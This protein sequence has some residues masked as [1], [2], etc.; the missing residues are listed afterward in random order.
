MTRCTRDILS[1]LAENRTG[2]GQP[3]TDRRTAGWNLSFSS[4]GFHPWPFSRSAPNATPCG[5]G[6]FTR[7][8][9]A[10]A[11]APPAGISC[12]RLAGHTPAGEAGKCR[13]TRS[14]R[15][16]SAANCTTCEPADPVC[17]RERPGGQRNRL[18]TSGFRLQVQKKKKH[19]AHA[20]LLP[21][22]KPV[23]CSLEPSARRAKP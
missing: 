17:G 6:S 7:S 19:P 16:T 1:D 3:G 4:E 5:R 18:Q 2:E 23:A 22:L 20:K 9:C 15:S 14:A 13:S 8:P 21:C 10:S 11:V 12:N